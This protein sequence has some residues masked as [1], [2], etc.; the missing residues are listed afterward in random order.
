[1][2]HPRF[3][4]GLI[5]L[6]PAAVFAAKEP[7]LVDVQVFPPNVNLATKQDRQPVVV[8]AVYADGVTRDVTS[9][10][11]YSLGNKSLAKLDRAVFHPLADG[12]TE[13]KVSFG[14]RT[15]TVPVK[16]EQSG[17]EAPVSFSK[18]VVPALSKAGC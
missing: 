12:A 2:K 17:V 14:G 1:M 9:E 13:L 7:A 16:V 18:D 8:Q 6:V 15:L 5:S 4:L 3:L 10:A 11:K